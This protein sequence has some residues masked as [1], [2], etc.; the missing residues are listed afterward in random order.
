MSVADDPQDRRKLV[1]CR[2]YRQEFPEVEDLVMV[3]ITRLTETGVYAKLLEYNDM[4]GLMI[5]SEVSKRRFRSIH[6]LVRVGRQEIVLVLRVDQQKGYVDLSK[7]RVAPEDREECEETWN[8]SKTVH[9]I[10]QHV[11]R[12]C[13]IPLVEVYTRFGWD[14]YDKFAHAL[15]GLKF[16][17]SDPDKFHEQFDVPDAIKDEL[18]SVIKRRLATQAVK[19]RADV[20]VTCFT[21]DGIESIKKALRAGQALSSPEISL[22]VNLIA[23]PQYCITT[24]VIDKE[25]GIAKLTEVCTAIRTEIVSLGGNFS[26]KE[27]ARVDRRELDEDDL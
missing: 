17:L 19:L 5:L 4:E 3:E 13:K 27:S 22:Q 1:S 15:D 12:V 26:Q 9:T 24:T 21:Y 23:P 11:C 8:K 20:E 10:L 14:L 25:A 7:K 16:L 18:V 2:M 6:K